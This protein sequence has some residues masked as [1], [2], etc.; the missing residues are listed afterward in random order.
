M[1]HVVENWSR[2]SGCVEMWHP[3]NAQVAG[4]VQ[5]RVRCVTPVPRAEGEV[6]PSLLRDAEGQL[7]A[8]RLSAGA[9]KE[10]GVAEGRDIEL[11][12]RR[13]RDPDLWF[14]R[15]VP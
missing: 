5:I 7:L 2:V 4:V 3:P 13:G 14:G 1:V 10:L 12:V 11:D 9:A 8:V 6:Y 15:V